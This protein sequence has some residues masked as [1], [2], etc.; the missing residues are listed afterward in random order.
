MKLLRKE[1]K[2]ITRKAIKGAAI[3]LMMQNGLDN[4]QIQDICKDADVA[5]GTFYVHFKN[6]DEI[7]NELIEDFNAVIKK[8]VIS[9]W[10][11]LLSSNINS[12]LYAIAETYLIEIAN[13][14]ALL[15][16]LSG[17][18]KGALPVKLLSEGVN[19]TMRFFIANKLKSRTKLKKF[20]EE[21]IDFIIHSILSVWIGVG[22]KH[23]LSEKK[24][25]SEQL[26]ELLVSTTIGIV[27]THI[28]E[29]NDLLKK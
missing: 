26:K 17:N 14:K 12:A 23:A 13:Q 3:K 18:N 28:P 5:Q 6:K 11:K 22:I 4:T 9:N 29:M 16:I 19:P 7:L 24:V 1:Q 25:T 8:S 27:T 21:Y 20:S 2:D 15:L 10:P